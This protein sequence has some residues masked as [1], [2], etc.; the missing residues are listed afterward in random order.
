M[1]NNSA[2]E[3]NRVQRAAIDDSETDL[4]VCIADIECSGHRIRID[5]RDSLIR[6]VCNGAIHAKFNPVAMGELA[7]LRA[8]IDFAEKVEAN[9]LKYPRTTT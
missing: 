3:V 8:A 2:E 5:T 4:R 6:V 7:A 1:T 9:A